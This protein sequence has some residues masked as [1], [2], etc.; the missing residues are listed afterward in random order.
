M[1]GK[2][3]LAIVFALVTLLFGCGA[4]DSGVTYLPENFPA[5]SA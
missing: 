1:G 2:C 4:V 5:A 3:A